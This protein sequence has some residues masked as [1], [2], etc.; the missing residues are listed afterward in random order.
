M[1]TYNG[2]HIYWDI[3]PMCPAIAAA[4]GVVNDRWLHRLLHDCA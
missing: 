1:F 3:A 4:F 2:A